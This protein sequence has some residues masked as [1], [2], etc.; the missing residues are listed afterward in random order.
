MVILV[1][2][3]TGFLGSHLIKALYKN[4][5]IVIL[6]RSFSQTN[7]ID[8]ILSKITYYDIDKIS[9]EEFFSKHRFDI[10]IHTATNYGKNNENP[11]EII[12]ANLLLPLDLLNYA[13]QTQVK[14]F[15]NT[16]TF[17][18]KPQFK[19]YKNLAYYQ[20]S[21]QNLCQW[22]IES[23]NKDKSLKIINFRLEHIYGAYDNESKFV[24]TIIRKLLANEK[25]IDLT[26]GSQKRDFIYIDD[27]VSAYLKILENINRLPQ[28]FIEFEVGT[29]SSVK[30]RKFVKLLKAQLVNNKTVLNFGSL[31][32]SNNEIMKS[33]AKI[34]ALKALDWQPQYNVETGIKELFSRIAI[35]HH[36]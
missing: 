22:L 28:G 35:R 23:A 14:A 30:L 17:F 13:Y 33:K 8:S 9:L 19:N 31:A 20:L 12:K 29:G 10:I 21:K 25:A 27:V 36:T 18:N 4:H 34:N 6:K 16:D 1:T 11:K 2:G 5:D 7:R 24:P 26:L 15:L 32:M 3:A